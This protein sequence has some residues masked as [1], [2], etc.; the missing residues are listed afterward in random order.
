M[1]I[2]FAI[3]L[4]FGQRIY[5]EAPPIPETIRLESGEVLFSGEDIRRGQNV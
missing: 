5:Q 4:Y 1:F 2:M 3:L